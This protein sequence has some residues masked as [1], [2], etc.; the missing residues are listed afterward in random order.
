MHKP[1][2][3]RTPAKVP[4]TL[5]S[6]GNS[7]SKLISSEQKNP[8]KSSKYK[9]KHEFNFSSS[10][11]EDFQQF[12]VKRTLAH[13]NLPKVLGSADTY[14]NIKNQMPDLDRYDEGKSKKNKTVLKSF[15][16]SSSEDEVEPKGNSFHKTNVNN[17]LSN[18]KTCETERKACLTKPLQSNRSKAKVS[19]SFVEKVDFEDT[20]VSCVGESLVDQDTVRKSIHYSRDDFRVPTLSQNDIFSVDDT[21]VQKPV[22]IS[23][24][25]FSPDM[26]M[27]FDQPP[28]ESTRIHRRSSVSYKK[29]LGSPEDLNSSGTSDDNKHYETC[30]PNV[31]GDLDNEP[32]DPLSVTTHEVHGNENIDKKSSD[33]MPKTIELKV[34]GNSDNFNDKQNN[35]LCKEL[36][37]LSIHQHNSLDNSQSWKSQKKICKNDALDNDPEFIGTS[38]E[39]SF[40]EIVEVVDVYTQT[41]LSLSEEDLSPLKHSLSESGLSE[42][43]RKVLR[44][45]SNS[46]VQS[47]TESDVE[48]DV[49][50]VEIKHM[51][52]QT[53]TCLNISEVNINMNTSVKE[54][55]QVNSDAII[56]HEKIEIKEE[57]SDSDVDKQQD[58]SE[59]E[60]IIV[61]SAHRIGADRDKSDSSEVKIN[62][63]GNSESEE[64]ASNITDVESTGESCSEPDDL[65]SESEKDSKRK[66]VKKKPLKLKRKGVQSNE[67]DKKRTSG[68]ESDSVSDDT[69]RCQNHLPDVP[70]PTEVTAQNTWRYVD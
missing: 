36:H 27:T 9:A 68:G 40:D 56:S 48:S 51:S 52:V 47:V 12:P 46:S 14:E 69:E 29:L 1:S 60:S 17:A 11:D 4:K 70:S 31:S 26:D 21:I 62:E 41:E 15:D 22:R 44:K 59:N 24:E 67:T 37:N 65:S 30:R 7:K 13:T 58:L 23:P 19:D 54:N 3:K 64:N 8:A 5:G 38:I 16:L 55:D 10:D 28:C 33:E 35:D 20:F 43:H 61:N 42:N 49:S 6:A 18:V 50:E 63:K 57:T 66:D 45:T 53:D 25:S 39:Q 34:N 32:E 2:E